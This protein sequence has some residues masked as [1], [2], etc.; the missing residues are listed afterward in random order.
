MKIRNKAIS[1]IILCFLFNSVLQ[2]K[3]LE[4][5]FDKL[6]VGIGLGLDY[7]GI[8]TNLLY[9]PQRTIGLFG[10]IGYNIDGVGLNGGLKLRLVSEK[11]YKNWNP[12]LIGMYGYNTVVVEKGI[13]QFYHTQYYGPSIGI[14]LD[15]RSVYLGQGYWTYA[16]FYPF[17]STYLRNSFDLYPITI[18]IG[19]RFILF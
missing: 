13:S 9:N 1:I 7:G 3:D 6:S 2:A 18:S 17:R 4:T 8:G 5:K 15:Y 12:Y 19:Y 16:I 10:A 11:N 14:G